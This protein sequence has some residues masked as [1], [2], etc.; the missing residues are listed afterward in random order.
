MGSIARNK[1]WLV[2]LSAGMSFFGVASAS[3]DE[4]ADV[5]A[6]RAAT[7]KY[8]DVNIALA[9]GYV[10]DP[11]G[12]CVSA[13]EEGLPAELGAMGIHY[14]NMEALQLTANAPRVDGMSTYTDFQKP[15]VLLYEPQA[16]GSLVLVAVEN[17][18][19]QAAWK[20]AGNAEPPM[21]AGKA[22]DTMADDPNTP[23][24]EAHGFAPHFDRHVWAFR[25][26]PAGVQTPFN[27]SVTCE[28][29]KAAAQ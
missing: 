25:D 18:V 10:P 11:A 14:L 17:L 15:A 27:P 4:A 7:E 24:D 22:W 12:I 13:A 2:A 28:Y 9:E 6:V 20:A 23:A 3:A 5:A 8:Q 1:V 29:Q 16:D 19:F 26:N 21:F